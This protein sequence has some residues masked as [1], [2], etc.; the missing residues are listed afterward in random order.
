MKLLKLLGHRGFLRYRAS[1]IPTISSMLQAAGFFVICAAQATT[2]AL[3]Y[4]W[5]KTLK[6]IPTRRGGELASFT[7]ESTRQDDFPPCGRRRP[8]DRCDRRDLSTASAR[9]GGPEGPPYKRYDGE[10]A[11]SL[12]PP[13]TG[14]AADA[15]VAIGRRRHS[16]RRT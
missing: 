13:T 8:G 9:R 15:I 1:N 3:Q 6:R 16:A 7:R 2:P 10:T 12:H 5:Q 4:T 11:A 14:P